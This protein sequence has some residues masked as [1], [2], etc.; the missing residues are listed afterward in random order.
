VN[1]ERLSAQRAHDIVAINQPLPSR[2][3]SLKIR[4]LIFRNDSLDLLGLALDAVPNSPVGF[5]RHM[6]Y[7]GVNRW[8]FG[9]GPALWALKLVANVFIQLIGI[10]H[11]CPLRCACE[12]GGGMH[13]LLP[14]SDAHR[15]ERFASVRIS[16]SQEWILQHQI[17]VPMC[18]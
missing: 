16:S 3:R 11:V 18:P 2:G 1:L 10:R 9:S 6:L 5:D 8:P 12:S 7:N 4:K 14:D 13:P 15:A 17:S